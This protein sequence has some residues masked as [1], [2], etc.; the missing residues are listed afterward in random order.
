MHIH[1]VWEWGHGGEPRESLK[2]V[3]LIF[4]LCILRLTC[5]LP[6]AYL[7]KTQ[8]TD[9]S[10]CVN[11]WLM[12][13]C[14]NA[15]CKVSTFKELSRALTFKKG[16]KDLTRVGSVWEYKLFSWVYAFAI[17]HTPYNYSLYIERNVGVILRC[18][19]EI[20]NL[21]F[22][23]TLKLLDRFLEINCLICDGINGLPKSLSYSIP[24]YF[25]HLLAN[26]CII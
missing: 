18:W 1:T 19:I 8:G 15:C 13:M 14:N 2:V 21:I 3:S 16:G 17:P 24:G 5:L 7:F 12:S 11:N 26:Q 6:R 23:E 9:P 25:L 22:C 4:L 20:L 10:H